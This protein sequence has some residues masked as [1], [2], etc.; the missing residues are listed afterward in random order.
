MGFVSGC[1]RGEGERRSSSGFKEGLHLRR[2]DKKWVKTWSE[3][4]GRNKRRS[5]GY[6]KPAAVA[7]KGPGLCAGRATGNG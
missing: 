4:H 1:G 5:S 6:Q 3:G 7:P 2:E